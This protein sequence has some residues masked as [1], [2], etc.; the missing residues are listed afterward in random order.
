MFAYLL[1]NQ[2]GFD[3]F[4][5]ISKKTIEFTWATPIFLTFGP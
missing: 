5:T 2:L 4:V 3:D 1:A